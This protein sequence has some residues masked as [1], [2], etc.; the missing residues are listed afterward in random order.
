SKLR[1]L[2]RS[3]S[4][5]KRIED[6]L[7]EIPKLERPLL[8]AMDADSWSVVQDGITLEHPYGNWPGIP[9]FKKFNRAIGLDLET[10]SAGE[11]TDHLSAIAA[12][13]V[14]LTAAS[15]EELSADLARLIEIARSVKNTD[16]MDDFFSSFI[17]THLQVLAEAPDTWASELIVKD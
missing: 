9:D 7:K 10:V 16:Q 14:S 1:R 12:N 3:P 8:S 17:L 6:L 11:F 4:D 15:A 2:M 5:L 13:R